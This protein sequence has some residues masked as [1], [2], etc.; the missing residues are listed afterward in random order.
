DISNHYKIESKPSKING[1][2]FV[3]SGNND[4]LLYKEVENLIIG[5]PVIEITNSYSLKSLENQAVLFKEFPLIGT[6]NF[7]LPIFIQH[8]N[9]RPTEP[10]DGIVTKRELE[11]TEEFTPD[12]N[13]ACL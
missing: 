7:N 8:T 9:F 13:R 10:R 2:N 5:V 12:I 1:L 6:E 4:G 11:D 3:S